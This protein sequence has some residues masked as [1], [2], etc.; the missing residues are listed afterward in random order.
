MRLLESARARAAGR[1]GSIADR[2]FSARDEAEQGNAPV[3]FL[4][5]S[6]LSIT[7][8]LL[9]IQVALIMYT[10]I[11]YIDAA[12]EGARV[13]GHL[14]S[15]L[16]LGI[17]HTQRL[18]ASLDNDAQVTGQFVSSGDAQIV[19]ITVRARLPILGAFSVTNAVRVTGRGLVETLDAQ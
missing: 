9:L 19:E 16:D 10:N 18:V 1:W 13:A 12:S 15:N 17:E 8:F 11:A 3:G 2:W 5:T 14:G 7:V 6:L 4:F